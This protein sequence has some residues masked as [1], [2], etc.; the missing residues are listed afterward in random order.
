MGDDV[1]LKSAD[2]VMSTLNDVASR[3]DNLLL[4]VGLT[5][6]GGIPLEYAS[7][8]RQISEWLAKNGKSI[9]DTVSSPFGLLPA[10]MCTTKGSQMYV[11]LDSH[12]APTPALPG[13]QVTTRKAW[14]LSTGKSLEF[15]NASETVVIPAPLPD[16]FVSTVAIERIRNRDGVV[17]R[18]G[19]RS[20][21]A[22]YVCTA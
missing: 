6:G 3:G 22:N 14:F 15:D 8:P 18:R 21:D 4:N 13:L 5:A 9:Y 11:H 12:S 17:P 19:R 1:P 20:R 16:K 7:Q 2:E 10:N